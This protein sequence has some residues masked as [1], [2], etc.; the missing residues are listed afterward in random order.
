MTEAICKKCSHY[1]K[2][3]RQY[4]PNCP[5]YDPQDTEQTNE[6]WF[7]GLSTEEKVKALLNLHEKVRQ[8]MRTDIGG[9]NSFYRGDYYREWLK[10]KHNHETD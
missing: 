8:R 3:V 5:A 9:E 7:C 6:E 10:E 2:C 1:D 4:Y